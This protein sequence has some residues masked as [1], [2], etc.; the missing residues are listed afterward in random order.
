MHVS[1]NQEHT[2]KYSKRLKNTVFDCMYQC[3]YSQSK[4]SDKETHSLVLLFTGTFKTQLDGNGQ[5]GAKASGWRQNF[6]FFQQASLLLLRS[7]AVWMRPTQSIKDNLLEIHWLQ[8]LNN[9]HRKTFRATPGF[10]FNGTA[11]YYD[12]AKWT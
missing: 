11:M 7:S 10:M 6:F 1:Q 9:I 3:I 12:L 4:E 5:A 2:G 8:M